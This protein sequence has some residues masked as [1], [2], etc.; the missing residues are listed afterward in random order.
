M[1]RRAKRKALRWYKDAW[2]HLHAAGRITWC[3][4]LFIHR[5]HS[6]DRVVRRKTHVEDKTTCPDCLAA[7]AAE[8]LRRIAMQDESG[9]LIMGHIMLGQ[10][11]AG[12]WVP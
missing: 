2:V 3:A 10:S 9:A 8:K 4:K 7:L 1:S 12:G 11:N 6:R 5:H